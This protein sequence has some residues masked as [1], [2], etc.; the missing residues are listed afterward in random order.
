V[1]LIHLLSLP[2]HER[3]GFVHQRAGRRFRRQ[4]TCHR[5]VPAAPSG[6]RPGLLLPLL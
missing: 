4:A 3:P 2:V 1:L 6:G 5:P